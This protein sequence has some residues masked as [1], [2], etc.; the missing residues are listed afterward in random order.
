MTSSGVRQPRLDLWRVLV[1][2]LGI[3]LAMVVSFYQVIRVQ[4]EDDKWQR[5][6][7]G[8]AVQERL[9]NPIRGDILDAQG[10][11]LVTSVP[12]YDLYFDFGAEGLTEA[13]F[14]SEVNALSQ[15][16]ADYFRDR[17]AAEYRRLLWKGYRRKHRYYRIKKGLSYYEWQAVRQFPIFRHERPNYIVGLI[18][19]TRYRRLNIHGVA[20]RLLGYVHEGGGKVGMEGAFDKWLMGERGVQRMKKTFRGVWVPVDGSYV[21]IPRRGASVYSTIDLQIQQIVEQALHRAVVRHRARWGTVVVMETAT[22]AIRALANAT[23]QPDSSYLDDRNY[24]VGE[25]LEP[26]STMKLASLLVLLEDARMHP[27]DTLDVSEGYYRIFDRT[28]RD[29]LNVPRRPISLSE[30]F[31]YSSNVAFAR[32]VFEHYHDN[33]TRFI[34]WLQ[35]WHLDHELDLPIPGEGRPYIPSPQDKI[36]SGTTLPWMAFGYGLKLTPIQLLTFYNA[37][38]NG[39]RMVRP[40]FAE[41]AVYPNGDVERFDFETIVEEIAPKEVLDTV[42]RMMRDVVQKGTARRIRGGRVPIAGKTGTVWIHTGSGYDH[43]RYRASFVGFFPAD[44]P[45]YTVIVV[46]NDPQ[47]IYYS[48]GSVAAP[49]VKDIAEAMYGQGLIEGLHREDSV[50][51]R[52]ARWIDRQ[53]LPYPVVLTWAQWYNSMVNTPTKWNM[54]DWVFT[55]ARSD[56]SLWLQPVRLIRSDVPNVRGMLVG[57]AT[58]LLE[59]AGVAVQIVGSGAVVRAQSLPAGTPIRSP[60]RIILWTN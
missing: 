9:V 31:I 43:N 36:W 34:R 44:Q 27:D 26:G 54:K 59:C 23:L 48:G 29:G 37:I 35:R 39:G 24:A 40:R 2:L 21:V 22:G 42:V 53:K 56:D 30:A 7:H 57:D 15:T 41:K 45:Q 16:L 18:R 8:Y 5:Y 51:W 3:G 6:A 17:S 52:P 58:Y 10:R 14:R 50:R 49:V 13:I 1:V 33:P 32:W 28:V 25:A 11:I 38:A 19:R 60:Q 4:A 47:G 12:V 46:I 55:T 20:R